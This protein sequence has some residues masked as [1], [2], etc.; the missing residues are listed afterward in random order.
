MT[1]LTSNKL[2]SNLLD[3]DLNFTNISVNETDVFSPSSG[4]TSF[5]ANSGNPADFLA[6]VLTGM[7]WSGVALEA[8]SDAAGDPS[9]QT[10]TFSYDVSVTDSGEFITSIDSSYAVDLQLGNGQ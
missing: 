7:S 8:F 4:V 10:L 2:F 6:G 5:T 3:G 1:T 9:T